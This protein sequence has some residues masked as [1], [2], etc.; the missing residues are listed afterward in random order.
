MN[1][2][3]YDGIL[4]FAKPAITDLY[5]ECRTAIFNNHET[6][7]YTPKGKKTMVREIGAGKAGTYNKTQ[8]WMQNYGR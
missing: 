2:T 8:G 5:L 1:F 3:V 6:Q 7:I 4:A